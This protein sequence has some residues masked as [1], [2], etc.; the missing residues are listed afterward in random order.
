MPAGAYQRSTYRPRRRLAARQ[1]DSVTDATLVPSEWVN[2][3]LPSTR[4]GIG[5]SQE[6]GGP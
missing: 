6:T 5:R 4:R 2:L 3:V 1:W